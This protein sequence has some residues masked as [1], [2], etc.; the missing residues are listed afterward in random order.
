MAYITQAELLDFLTLSELVQL[1]DDAGTGLV[2]SA[3]VT[4]ALD[5][6]SAEIDAYAGVK[7]STPLQTS[8]KVK[9]LA[10]DVAIYH[11]EKRRRT[12]REDTAKAYEL[13]IA[14]LKDV[15][16]GRAQLDQPVGETPQSG[17]QEVRT[18]ET[19]GPFTDDNL[20]NF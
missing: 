17:S 7:Y 13:A 11:L 14:F 12:V 10:R 5:A 15:A 8:V 9:Q 16:A 6:A 2:D 4:A 20:E 19:E 1:T 18:T 3:K